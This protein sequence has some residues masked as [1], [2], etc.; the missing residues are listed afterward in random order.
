MKLVIVGGGTSGWMTA[1]YLLAAFGDRLDITLVESAG[2]SPVGVGEATFSEFRHFFSY[3]G[4]PEQEWMP[5]CE[6]TYKLAVRFE[7]WRQPDH[8]FYHPFEPMKLVRGLTLADWWLH[9][10]EGSRFDHDCFVVAAICDAKRSPRHLDGALFE[11]DLDI[12]HHL[13]DSTLSDPSTQFTY[14]YHFDAT[15]LARYLAKR[16]TDQGVEHVV[17]TVEHVELDERGWIQHVVAGEHGNIEGDLFIDCTGFRSLLMSQALREPFVSFQAMLPNDRA[18]ALRVPTD[19]S[20]EIRP[21]TTATAMESGWIW[22]IPLYS[23]IGTGY[24]YASDYCSPEEAEQ[25]LRARIGPAADDLEANHIKMRVGRSERSWVNN[26][27]AIGLSSAF[28]E[29]LESTGIFFIQYAVDQLVRHFPAET[30]DP[31]IV[32][33]FNSR[34]ARCVDGVREFLALHYR[35][36]GRSDTPYW[37]DAHQRLL[38]DGLAERMDHWRRGIPEPD[39]IYPYYHGFEPYSYICMLMGLGGLPLQARP[40]L[41]MLDDGTARQEFQRVRARAERVIETLPGH[42]E[43]LRHSRG[44]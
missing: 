7:N 35:T 12:A 44:V 28:V 39:T 1:T 34:V 16:G 43:Y 10:G 5:Q 21:C 20:E 42:L 15:L 25:T 30:W 37:K 29:P 33:S 36:A 2:V 23:R 26:C 19:G 9:L 31:T 3:L 6:A 38:P 41:G 18:V 27:V 22:T 17:G 4:I 14:A 24:V 8:Y 11:S 40:V 32:A 13:Q